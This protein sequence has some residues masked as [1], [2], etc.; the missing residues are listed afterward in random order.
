MALYNVVAPCIVGG[1]HYTR[2]SKTPV[3]V[4]NAEAKELLESGAIELS[5]EGVLKYAAESAG[6]KPQRRKRSEDSRRDG[7]TE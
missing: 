3:E 7:Q 5:H 2:P 1:K 4:S 6:E